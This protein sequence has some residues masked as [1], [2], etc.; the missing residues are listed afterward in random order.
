M[1]R[2]VNTASTGK[3]RNQLRRTIAELLRRLSQKGEIDDD[4]KDMVAM[5]VYSLNEIDAGIQS[6]AEAWEKRD[7]WIK[8]EGFRRE[9]MWVNDIA[10]ELADIV[11]Q[12]GWDNLP[13]TMVK[14]IPRFADINVA[15]YT[16]SPDEWKGKH[17][18][19]IHELAG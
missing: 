3:R 1:G 12:G 16:R 9:W 11:E 6:S 10:D 4:A 14:L 5:I 7:Y 2:I 13:T 15:K 17:A 18:D 19:L 8:A